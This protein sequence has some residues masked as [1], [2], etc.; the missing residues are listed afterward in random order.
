MRAVLIGEVDQARHL[1]SIFEKALVRSRCELVPQLFLKRCAPKM[2]VGATP[3]ADGWLARP[4]GVRSA[5]SNR[6][7]R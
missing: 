5:S 2:I 1:E 4:T 6:L 3:G 7:P